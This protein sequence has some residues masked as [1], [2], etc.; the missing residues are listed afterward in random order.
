MAE[1]MRG[2]Q[3]LPEEEII[4]TWKKFCDLGRKYDKRRA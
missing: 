1:E 4:D 3:E 2:S